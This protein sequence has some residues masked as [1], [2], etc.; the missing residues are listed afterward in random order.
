MTD[1]FDCIIMQW[2]QLSFNELAL[3]FKQKFDPPIGRSN[4]LHQTHLN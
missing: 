1:C 2:I 3:S 4:S